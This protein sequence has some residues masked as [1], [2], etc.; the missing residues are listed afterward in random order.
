M[1]ICRALL[2]YGYRSF[3]LEILEYCEPSLKLKR[4]KYYINLLKPEY[5]IS[6]DPTA[7]FAGRK[8]S[9]K[10]KTIMSDAKKGKAKIEGSGRPAQSIE[11]FDNKNNS[12]T[13]YDSIHA[14]ARA[15]DIKQP[16]ISTY[17]QRNQQKPYK[18]RYI[19][20]KL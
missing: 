8:H 11:V 19:F 17:F 13:I 6:F 15:L 12:T 18:G 9:D 10:S 20:F 16:R 14:A 3:S 1:A 2:K 7:S 5:N 4:E